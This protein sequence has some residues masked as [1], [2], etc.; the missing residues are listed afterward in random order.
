[1]TDS[2]VYRRDEMETS[3]SYLI[4]FFSKY[5]R[6]SQVYCRSNQI[7]CSIAEYLKK[8]LLNKNLLTLNKISCNKRAMMAQHCSSSLYV[9]IPPSYQT[10]KYLGIGLKHKTPNTGLKVMAIVL[11]F[12]NKISKYFT[13]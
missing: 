1:M 13:I 2:I 3:K 8:T 12:S 7:P 10:L 5:A 6:N 11:M 4:K 9:T